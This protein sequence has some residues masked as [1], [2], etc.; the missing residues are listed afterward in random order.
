[1]A[2]DRRQAGL[3]V[4]QRISSTLG[5]SDPRNRRPDNVAGQIELVIG[6]GLEVNKQGKIV[7]K[8]S[9]DDFEFDASG[10]LRIRR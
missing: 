3:N 2:Q 7:L 8:V 10:T 4:G 5:A 9:A 1:M 6:Q